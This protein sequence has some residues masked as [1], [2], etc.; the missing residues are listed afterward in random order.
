M[1]SKSVQKHL[2]RHE[3]PITCQATRYARLMAMGKAH[4]DIHLLSVW[5]VVVAFN[6]TDIVETPAWGSQE[7]VLVRELL[8]D[9]KLESH[10][11]C[12]HA[13]TVFKSQE[14][15]ITTNTTPCP[16]WPDLQI[17]HLFSSSVYQGWC[18]PSGIKVAGW[19][20]DA[21]AVPLVR[22]PPTD[23]EF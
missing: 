6:L 8:E 17:F 22:A 18:W 23:I 9:K 14:F 11:V 19:S 7:T 12:A 5:Q 16:F 2:R 4:A 20:G 10:T 1:E 13:L 21:S 15:W 3:T